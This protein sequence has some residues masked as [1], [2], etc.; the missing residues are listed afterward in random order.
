M[1]QNFILF[2]SKTRKNKKLINARIETLN[3]IKTA[4]DIKRADKIMYLYF[5]LES[6]LNE[7]KICRDKNKKIRFSAVK[8]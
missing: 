8:L 5:L 3:L 2:F 6:I 1:K 7:K 4:H